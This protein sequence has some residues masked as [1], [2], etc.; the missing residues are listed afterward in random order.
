MAAKED[1]DQ[2]SKKRRPRENERDRPVSRITAV[3]DEDEHC[4][5]GRQEQRPPSTNQET[6]DDAWD[7][8][9][10][11]V[12]QGCSKGSPTSTGCSS[13]SLAPAGSGLITLEELGQGIGFP[14]EVLVDR[15][16]DQEAELPRR[17]SLSPALPLRR[18][19]ADLDDDRSLHRSD[20]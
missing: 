5:G 17:R 20:F 13:C 12:V 6:D 14:L 16:S 10:Q 11:Q 8:E 1:A 3:V 9:G 19:G 7:T 18:R 2:H 4:P 15:G